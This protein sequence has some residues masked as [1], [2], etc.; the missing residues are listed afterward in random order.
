M[1]V[2]E[3]IAHARD[4]SGLGAFTAGCLFVRGALLAAMLG[5]LVFFETLR[6]AAGRAELTEARARTEE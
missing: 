5:A 3:A 6:Y 2:R 1:G 4:E